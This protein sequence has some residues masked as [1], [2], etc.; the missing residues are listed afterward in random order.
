[1]SDELEKLKQDYRNIEAPPHLATR[2]RASVAQETRRRHAWMPVA[3]ATAVAAAAIW[4][5]P[6][7]EQPTADLPRKPS[8][9]A[10][11][12]LKPQ[13]PS[14]SAPSLSQIKTVSVPKMPAKPAI[15]PAKP[16]S[17]SIHDSEILKEKDH[18]NV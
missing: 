1:M 14:V 4:L 5:I 12:S 7:G 13:K 9:S 15:K 16:Q 6:F 3:A 10:L 8:L 11:A 17:N 18:A 2:V